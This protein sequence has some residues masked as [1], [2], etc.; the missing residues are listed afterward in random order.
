M[1]TFAKLS[2][3]SRRKFSDTSSCL[4]MRF[5]VS[6]CFLIFMNSEGYSSGGFP[7]LAMVSFTCLSSSESLAFVK[8]FRCLQ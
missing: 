1:A 6:L 3:E 7:Y 8:P 2:V 4:G 5:G